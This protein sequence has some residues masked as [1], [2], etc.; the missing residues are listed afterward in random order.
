M[1]VE[2]QLKEQLSETL[3][4]ADTVTVGKGELM[5]LRA[6]LREVRSSFAPG[7]YMRIG[8][9][10][11]SGGPVEYQVGSTVKQVPWVRGDVFITLPGDEGLFHTPDLEMIGLAIHLEAF[12]CIW[13]TL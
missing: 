5:L 11:S 8:L 9:C 13:E 2:H 7:P 6:F 3:P 1:G 10:M 4:T 12:G